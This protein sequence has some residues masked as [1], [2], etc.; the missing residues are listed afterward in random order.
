MLIWRC[1]AG[2]QAVAVIE[3]VE[4]GQAVVDAA[5][6]AFGTVHGVINNAGILRDKSFASMTEAEWD[7]VYATHLKGS[8]SVTHA[9]WPIFL[10]QKY[11]RVSFL[12]AS[13]HFN[14][15]LI[16]NVRSDRLSTR[17]PLLACMATSD[18]L[19]SRP[20]VSPR[21]LPPLTTRPEVPLRRLV[22]SVSAKL[23]PAK[24]KSIIFTSIALSQ[25]RK[26]E[27]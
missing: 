12:I 6:K 15:M 2:G 14:R 26:L 8:Y 5:C 24:A 3:S 21:C 27:I 22:S 17:L 23:L 16:L 19:T 25:P 7:A 13:L 4:N 9:L 20:Y 18:R 10:K 1:T 11:G